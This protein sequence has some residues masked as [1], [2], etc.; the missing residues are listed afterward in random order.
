MP[1]LGWLAS[2]S[3]ELQSEASLRP[4]YSS[5]KHRSQISLV[6][7]KYVHWKTKYQQ[8]CLYIHQPEHQLS[9]KSLSE[10]IEYIEKVMIHVGWV[11]LFISL[12]LGETELLLSVSPPVRTH[13]L[14]VSHNNPALNAVPTN[15]NLNTALPSTRLAVLFS[16]RLTGG[17]FSLAAA[18][19]SSKDTTSL[20]EF[21]IPAQDRC[22]R[23]YEVELQGI[24][25][26]FWSAVAWAT[27]QWSV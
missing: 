17:W 14:T 15:L 16:V 4:W 13:Y 19:L 24:V 27:C 6:T 21:F 26:L 7:Q 23:W 1:S 3:R 8:K 11:V 18:N 9:V 22:R 2:K 20:K 12:H 10:P 25:Q 5:K